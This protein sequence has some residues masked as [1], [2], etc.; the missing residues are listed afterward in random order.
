MF[1]ASKVKQTTAARMVAVTISIEQRHGEL[2]K[3]SLD[4]AMTS[5]GTD[6]IDLTKRY[7]VCL[8]M[9]PSTHCRVLFCKLI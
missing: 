2:S 1:M 3:T 7:K 4:S 8:K 5:S 9:G 6:S